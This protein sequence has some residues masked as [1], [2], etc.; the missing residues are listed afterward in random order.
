M[1][2]LLT[3]VA[4]VQKSLKKEHFLWQLSN[5]EMDFEKA[6]NDIDAEEKGREEIVQ[7]LE[8]YESESSRKKKEQAKYLKEIAQCEKKIAERKNRL[9]K[10]VSSIILN[11][12]LWYFCAK[13]CIMH[14]YPNLIN[15]CVKMSLVTFSSACHALHLQL[16]L[17]PMK[18]LNSP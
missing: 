18:L 3:N 14:I 6:N 16:K 2:I 10:N 11:R 7:E 15:L 4:R 9:D 13:H 8:T 17:G 12:L 5:L 1:N